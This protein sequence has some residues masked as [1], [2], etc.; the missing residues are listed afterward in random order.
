MS[1]LKGIGLILVFSLVLFPEYESL[2]GSAS[3]IYGTAIFGFRWIDLLLFGVCAFQL[4]AAIGPLSRRQIVP[5]TMR[6]PI[7]V[8][9]AAIAIATLYGYVQGG[10]HI[11][12]DWRNLLLG[13]GLTFCFACW[14]RT[15][16]ELYEVARI[17]ALTIGVATMFFLWRFLVGGYGTMQAVRGVKTP[18]WDGAVLHAAVVLALLAFRFSLVEESRLWKIAC[19][20]LA[21]AESLLVML[22]L[23]R[24]YWG[25]LAVG[26]TLLLILV[27]RRRL[28][29]AVLT[30]TL[31]LALSFAGKHVLA[32]AESFDI[33]A[34][35]ESPYT[36]TN[37]GHVGDVL[38]AWDHIKENPVMGIGL[39]R[40]YKTKRIRFWKTESW[41][42]HN[43]L[44]HTW[45][46][47]GLLGLIGY[48][49]F[50]T[51]LL[52]WLSR[53]QRMIKHPAVRAFSQVALASVA[54]TFVMS[55]GF[56]PW[57]YG[58]LQRNVVAA[59]ILGSLFS[60]V[61]GPEM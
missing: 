38:D 28:V 23:R 19:G 49:W 3:R 7:A 26:M 15:P 46:L 2:E 53:T 42:V 11:F 5:P 20:G 14:I 27:K 36:R 37:A 6:A 24:T 58:S 35:G 34:A 61:R 10:V 8:F 29:I 44:L 30:A 33:F 32:R 25:E 47:Y 18:L 31:I 56:T 43:A 60:V 13:A 57:P 1:L 52:G 39:A 50:H 4:L 40:P 59:F 21:L 41:G 55:L 16:E 51:R 12:F 9:A 17:F 54:G 45:L 22:S 48:V